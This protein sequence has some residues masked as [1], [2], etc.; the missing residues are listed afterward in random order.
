MTTQIVRLLSSK[1][2]AGIYQWPTPI[3]A[4][5]ELDAA[6]TAGWTVGIVRMGSAYGKSA[7]LRAFHRDLALP[8]WFGHN[9]DALVDALCDWQSAAARRLIVVEDL[10]FGDGPSA[11]LI[12]AIEG[13][14]EASKLVVVVTATGPVPGARPVVADKP[15]PTE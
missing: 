15:K 12:H 10:P 13:A 1:V 5:E 11:R 6:R 8:D 4:P 2:S 3:V 7:V 14:V 9:W